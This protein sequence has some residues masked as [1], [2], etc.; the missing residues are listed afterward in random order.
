MLILLIITKSKVCHVLVIL[1]VLIYV[2]T[3]VQHDFHIR[4]C[5][6]R[7]TETWPASVVEQELLTLPKHMSSPP[8]FS[9]V[10]V[11]RSLVLLRSLFDLL[12]C[13]ISIY[14]FRLSVVRSLV[15]FRSLFELLH[16]PTS[17]YVFRLSLWYLQTVLVYAITNKETSW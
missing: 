11:V 1:F 15:L 6:C 9:G 13:P 4:W 14:V 2:C 5:S 3:G 12:P 8:V 7:L 10:R 17:I 16:C